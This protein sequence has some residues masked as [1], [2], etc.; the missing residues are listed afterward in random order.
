MLPSLSKC[1][2]NAS[3][4]PFS[5]IVSPYMTRLRGLGTEKII[6]QTVNFTVTFLP[7]S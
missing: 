1:F 5:T 4:K 7:K 2:S 6:L 3:T